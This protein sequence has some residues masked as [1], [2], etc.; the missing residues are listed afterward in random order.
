L[1]LTFNL[2]Q[3]VHHHVYVNSL[4]HNLLCILMYFLLLNYAYT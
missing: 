3:D 1:D 4:S 2:A